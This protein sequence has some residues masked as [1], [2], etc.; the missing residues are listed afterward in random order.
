MRTLL[1]PTQKNIDECVTAT[2]TTY[3]VVRPNE[4]VRVRGLIY[5]A[6]NQQGIGDIHTS[7]DAVRYTLRVVITL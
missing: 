2:G 3:F 5:A 4:L 1:E 7:Y 6:L